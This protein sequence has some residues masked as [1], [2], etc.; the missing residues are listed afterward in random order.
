VPWACPAA[1]SSAFA[2]LGRLPVEPQILLM[3]E[4]ARALVPNPTARVEEDLVQE[5]KQNY[6]IV[7]VTHDVQQATRI[8]D[9]TA[10]FFD[11]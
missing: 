6:A 10:F 1:S 3:D 9:F 11:G 8:S 5:L 2:L 7:I 4:P